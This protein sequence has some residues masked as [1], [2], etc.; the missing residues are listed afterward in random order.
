MMSGITSEECSTMSFGYVKEKSD[1]DDA[2]NESPN[3]EDSDESWITTWCR[4]PGH[5]LLVEVS[6]RYMT[7]GDGFIGI[8]PWQT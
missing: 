6:E 3:M 4:K 5:D 8:K 1:S 2:G 7:E